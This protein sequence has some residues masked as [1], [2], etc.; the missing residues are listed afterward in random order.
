MRLDPQ[1]ITLYEGDDLPG[2]AAVLEDNAGNALDLT[3]ADAVYIQIRHPDGAVTE[4]ELTITGAVS[5]TVTY[6]WTGVQTRTWGAGVHDI[7]ARAAYPADAVIAPADRNCRLII[8]P[9]IGNV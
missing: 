2:F 5:G 9:E 4:D 6:D 1:E 7:T 8:R 3:T